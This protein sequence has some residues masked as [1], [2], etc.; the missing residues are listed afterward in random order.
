MAPTIASEPALGGLSHDVCSAIDGSHWPSALHCLRGARAP[1]SGHH[2][3]QWRGAEE[4]MGSPCQKTRR[5]CVPT[6][7]HFIPSGAA[8]PSPS[9]K[10]LATLSRRSF[11]S[12][13]QASS[14]ASA[15][16]D[17]FFGRVCSLR[18]RN[19]GLPKKE[20]LGTQLEMHAA[21]DGK[22]SCDDHM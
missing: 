5:S 3:A 8:S 18:K 21:H 9:P 12:F 17:C 13:T 2:C 19:D 15:K 16:L 7:I 10:A 20:Q 14:W 1:P 6:C 4:A 11:V 22:S